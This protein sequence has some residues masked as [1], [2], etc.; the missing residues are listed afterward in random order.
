MD[1]VEYQWFSFNPSGS[2]EVITLRARDV[3]GLRKTLQHGTPV[4]SIYLVP[5]FSIDDSYAITKET[6]TTIKE[7]LED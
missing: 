4:Y 6:Y 1:N 2:E 3:K 5:N 7:W